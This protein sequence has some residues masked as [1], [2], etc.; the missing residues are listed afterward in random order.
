VLAEDIL[1]LIAG[2]TNFV[3]LL[4]LMQ[5][6]AK[7]G[8]VTSESQAKTTANHFLASYFPGILKL[9]LEEKT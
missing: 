9:A 4:A 8:G 5:A 3:G 2:N 1:K 7:A 6:M